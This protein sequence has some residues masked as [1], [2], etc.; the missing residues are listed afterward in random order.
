MSGCWPLMRRYCCIMGVCAPRL[1]E[2]WVMSGSSDNVS[3]GVQAPRLVD[4]NHGVKESNLLDH[5]RDLRDFDRE[6]RTRS[7]LGGPGGELGFP[8]VRM[9]E[10]QQILAEVQETVGGVAPVRP[11]VGMK[12]FDEIDTVVLETGRIQAVKALDHVSAVMAAVVDDEIER[13]E[14]SHDAGKEFVIRLAADPDVNPICGRVEAGTRGIDI[15]AD[16]G[17]LRMLKITFPEAQGR[18]V[19]D[20]DLQDTQ[21]RVAAGAKDRFVGLEVV[22]PLQTLWRGAPELVDRIRRQACGRLVVPIG[23]PGD[24]LRVDRVEPDRR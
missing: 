10:L 3:G 4:G 24:G 15:D 20:S 19:K 23:S 9:H 13:A 22:G 8:V 11:V 18:A 17:G 16:Q 2:I 5:C 21:G 12:V 1:S 7:C 6:A 14:L